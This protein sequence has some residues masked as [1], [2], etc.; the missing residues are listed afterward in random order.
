MV[1]SPSDTVVIRSDL[2]LIVKEHDVRRT[3]DR[4]GVGVVVGR[5][6]VPD[7]HK[8]HQYI[9]REAQKHQKVMVC[10]G[11][12]PCLVTKEDPLD[13]PTRERM[14][15]SFAPE[16]TVVAIMDHSSD[17]EW[18]QRLDNLVRTYFP[19]DTATFYS[20]RDGFATCY[21]GK[22]KV[23][24]VDEIDFDSGTE[25]RYDV[26]K[27]V[28]ATAD[29]RKGVIY[30]AHNMRDRVIPAVDIAILKVTESAKDWPTILLGRKPGEE[31]FRLPGGFVEA[32]DRSFE[33]TA[34]RELMEETSLGV[35]DLTYLNSF[36]TEDWRN[37]GTDK[38]FTSLYLGF[39]TSG[40][41]RAGDDLEEVGWFRLDK[42]SDLVVDNHVCLIVEVLKYWTGRA[43]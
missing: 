31:K 15:K 42:A 18:S 33:A 30:A 19:V 25:I 2:P 21:S 27:K 43:V 28:K 5:F 4:P 34:R 13:F 7:L 11:I 1:R 24:E 38:I 23:K 8:G 32:K 10:I 6:Q 16:A 36:Q 37:N 40:A 35:N 26:G 29:F 12:H 3:K 22:S 39:H 9:I 20:G 14:I 17:E 41:I